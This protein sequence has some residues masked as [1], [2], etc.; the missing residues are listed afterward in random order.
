MIGL[1]NTYRDVARELSDGL[2]SGHVV[3]EQESTMDEVGLFAGLLFQYFAP[4]KVAFVVGSASS[5]GIFGSNSQI[6]VQIDP[7]DFEK[8]PEEVK[9]D[10]YMTTKDLINRGVKIKI[11]D[12]KGNMIDPL[13][14]SDIRTIDVSRFQSKIEP[15]LKP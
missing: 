9:A 1:R 10:F 4:R 11:K 7:K 13:A 2:R 5:M 8:M 14:Y 12:L 3:L 15:F 6:M